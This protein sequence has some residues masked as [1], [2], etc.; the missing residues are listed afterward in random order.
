MSTFLQ[1]LGS[2]ASIG[3]IPLAIYLYLRSREA[4]FNKLKREIVKILSYQIGEGRNLSS[5]EI[6][7][8]IFSKIREAGIKNN[9][10]FVSEI[11]EDLV[12]ETISSPMLESER[13]KEIL[14]NLRSIHQRGDILTA[15]DKYDLRYKDFLDG[16]KNVIRLTQ[17]DI[18]YVESFTTEKRV[19]Q[20]FKKPKRADKISEIFGFVAGIASVIA[21][22]VSLLSKTALLDSLSTF[23]KDNQQLLQIIL[24]ITASII[25]SVVTLMTAFL[26]R[27]KSKKALEKKGAENQSNS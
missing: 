3:S 5:F 15:I 24:G 19:E 10:L 9:T 23:F 8:V 20:I 16:I 17:E 14:N 21:V 1:F 4:R 12:T 27:K 26:S 6:Q 2:I 18:Q 7:S 25:A 11:V 22:F 13:K